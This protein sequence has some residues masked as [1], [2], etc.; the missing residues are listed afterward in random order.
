[1][2][3]AAPVAPA[4]ADNQLRPNTEN[5]QPSFAFPQM[6]DTVAYSSAPWMYAALMQIHDKERSGEKIVGIGDFTVAPKIADAAR[7]A[8]LSVL[9]PELPA[10]TVTHMSGG[11]LSVIWSVQKKRIELD[12]FPDGQVALSHF[13][14]D[15]LLHSR[16]MMEMGIQ[17]AAP[18]MA[19]SELR[20]RFRW[21]LRR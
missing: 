6:T 11:G 2:T 4:F 16:D 15:D 13:E 19:S 21:L 9:V 14:C 8:V 1:M 10:P 3:A 20:N 17:G 5:Y 7:T 12:V 18:L